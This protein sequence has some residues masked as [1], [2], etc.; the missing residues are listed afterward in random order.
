[1]RVALVYDRVNKFGGAERVLLDLHK[2]WPDAPIFTAVYNPETASWANSFRIH[3][4]F[5]QSIPFA[6]N[7]HEWFAFLTPLAFESFDFSDYDLVVSVSS[8]DAKGIITGPKTLH[9]SYCLTPTRYLW[10]GFSLYRDTFFNPLVRTGFSVLSPFLRMWDRVASTRPDTMVAISKTVAR[11]IKKYYRIDAP[12]IYPP[13]DTDCFVLGKKP[14]GSYFLVVS[15]LVPYKRVDLIIEAC[16]TRRLP[17][18]VVGT[19]SEKKRLQRLAKNTVSFA[20]NLTDAELVGYYQGCIALVHAGIEDF[21]ITSLEAQACGRPVI[22]FGA[23]GFKETIIAGKTGEFFMTQSVSSLKACLE[24]FH[25]Q[26]YKP[27]V[28]R[29]NALRFSSSVFRKSFSSY[30]HRYVKNPI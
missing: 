15:R 9:I 7:H 18:I 14:T 20:G 6:K 17:L 1:M 11:R 12:I 28:C 27:L 29:S 25:A 3:P 21:G 23:G 26:T 30:V 4:S 22:A 2:I 10:S 5:L 13:V 19:G 8:A 24:S 16:N